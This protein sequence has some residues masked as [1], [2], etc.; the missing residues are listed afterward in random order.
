MNE[1]EKEIKWG[2]KTEKEAIEGMTWEM[3]SGKN[4]RLNKRKERKSEEDDRNFLN[5]VFWILGTESS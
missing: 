1:R 3:K 5:G 4:K 2:R